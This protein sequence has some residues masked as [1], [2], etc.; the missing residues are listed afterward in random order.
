MAVHTSSD[1]TL[2]PT[3]LGR[4]NVRQIGTGPPAVLWHSLF[5]DSGSWD[6]LVNSLARHRRLV[7]IDGPGY[8]R[9]DPIDRDFT[10][11]D[12]AATA[13]EILDHLGIAEPVDW[14]GNAWGGHI[15]ITLAVEQ[16]RRLRS[17]VTIA[18]P[19]L[20]IGTRQRWTQTFPLAVL[21]RLTGPSR[22]VTK[23]L[24]D[25]LLGSAAISARPDRAG[26][27]MESFTRTDRASM[28][29]TIR[30]MHRWLPLTDT[31]QKVTVPTLFLTGDLGHRNWRPA[32]AHAAAAS[33]PNARVVA[34]TGTT[35]VGTLLLD[36][37]A[38]ADAVTAFWTS[39]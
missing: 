24:F 6:P 12:C 28:R 33:M 1:S 13:G 36:T 29:R 22:V 4:L 14:V 27:L 5:V 11:T 21:Y 8:G 39:P 38:I 25:S 23:L 17:L 19:L 35:Y 7:L 10:L 30:F 34:L 20:P 15:G 9:S 18:S 2:V 31:V 3:P 32:D 37:D 26:D 16:P